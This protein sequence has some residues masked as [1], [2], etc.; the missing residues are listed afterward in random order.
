MH[1][2]EN[3]A[4]PL[5]LVAVFVWCL[6]CIDVAGD[7]R[8]V[9]PAGPLPGAESAKTTAARRPDRRLGVLERWCGIARFIAWG[10][11]ASEMENG[12]D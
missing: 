3:V 11:A 2:A 12:G 4:R 8:G 10:F 7:V 9:T 5:E 1:R 6:L